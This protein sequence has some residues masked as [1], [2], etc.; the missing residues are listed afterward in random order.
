MAWIWCRFYTKEKDWRPVKFPPPGPYWNSGYGDD[1]NIMVAYFPQGL[2][3][4]LTEYWPDAYSIDMEISDAILF[5]TRFPKP[6]WLEEYRDA[7]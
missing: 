3:D 7:K 1:Y 5:T 6:D 2:E 4:T